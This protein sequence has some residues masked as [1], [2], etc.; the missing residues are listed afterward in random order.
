MDL[1][2]VVVVLNESTEELETR[3]VDLFVEARVNIYR[4]IVGKNCR[5]DTKMV[6]V[7]AN[8]GTQNVTVEI[9]H[10]YLEIHVDVVVFR[11]V[12]EN[13]KQNIIDFDFL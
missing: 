2:V 7:V 10:F 1:L 3:S 4:I 5:A 12:S 9:V 11:V 8:F 13:F 6:H